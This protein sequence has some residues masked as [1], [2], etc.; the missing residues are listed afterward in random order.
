MLT[1][2]MIDAFSCF[3][4][5]DA[6]GNIVFTLRRYGAVHDEDRNASLTSTII[7]DDL[8]IFATDITDFQVLV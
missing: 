2:V 4:V 3:A 5:H 8:A 6:K 1:C 7:E